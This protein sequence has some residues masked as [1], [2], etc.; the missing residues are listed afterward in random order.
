[1]LCPLLGKA[2]IS[3]LLE[4]GEEGLG[5]PSHEEL[6]LLSVEQS[7]AVLGRGSGGLRVQG[8]EWGPGRHPRELGLS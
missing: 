6:A 5:P 3:E 4:K 8:A 7:R 1:M 2:L